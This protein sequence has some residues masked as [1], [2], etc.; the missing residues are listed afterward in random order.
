M[1]AANILEG[2]QVKQT[3]QKQE[4]P[5]LPD[6]KS[7]YYGSTQKKCI[8]IVGEKIDDRAESDTVYADTKDDDLKYL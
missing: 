7:V 8:K 5:G 6:E 4:D 2:K 3:G 1:V